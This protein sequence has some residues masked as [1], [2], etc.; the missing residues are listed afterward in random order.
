MTRRLLL[1][2][3]GAVTALWPLSTIRL[4]A[5]PGAQ[6]ATLDRPTLLAVAEVVLPSS[7][8]ADERADAVSAF[9]TWVAGYRAG[10][11]AGHGYGATRPRTT[12]PSPSAAYP[13]QIAALDAA[14]RAEGGA[15]FA[16]LNPAARRRLIASALTT[17]TR[18]TQLPSRPS[19]GHV[20][21]DFMGL[22]FHG[23]QGYN[24]AYAAAINREDCRGL[25][26]SDRP[27]APLPAREGGH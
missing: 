17:P 19:G 26:G 2:L 9:V 18:I 7:L 23:P 6:A 4:F 24:L 1:R 11:D 10:A 12:G 15:S 3:A 21:A 27:P 13:G 8:T 16:D 25:D 14:A 22:Y 5:W 20:V